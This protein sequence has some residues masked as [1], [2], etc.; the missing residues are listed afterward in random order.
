MWTFL[1]IAS[2]TY[3]YKKCEVLVVLA[4]RELVIAAVLLLTVG[5]ILTF[6]RYRGLKTPQVLQLPLEI[7]SKLPLTNKIIHKSGNSQRNNA[8]GAKKKVSYCAVY[9]LFRLDVDYIYTIFTIYQVIQVDS[10]NPGFIL[11]Q[12]LFIIKEYLQKKC[13]F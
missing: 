1:G 10:L 11:Q 13:G 7:L 2:F 12:M 6:H 8:A 3:V 5:V 4:R 9:D